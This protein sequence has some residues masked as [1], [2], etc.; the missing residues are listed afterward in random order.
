MQPLHLSITSDG[1]FI[2]T[3]K[4]NNEVKVLSPEGNNLLLSFIAPNCD[5]TPECAVCNQG[6]FFVSYPLAGC[7]N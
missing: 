1:R 7:I 5:E 4:V 2:I 6:K 3:E